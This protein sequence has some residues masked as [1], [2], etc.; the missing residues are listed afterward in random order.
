MPEPGA[1]RGHLAGLGLFFFALAV[2][3]VIWVACGFERVVVA[4]DSMAPALLPGDRL[5]VRKWHRKASGEAPPSPQAVRPGRP[6]APRWRRLAPAHVVRVGDVVVVPDPRQQSR[7]LVKRVAKLGGGS[8]WLAGDNPARSTDSRDFGPVELGSIRGKAVYRYAPASRAGRLRLHDG[9]LGAGA[10]GGFGP[11]L[12][13]SL[14]ACGQ[15][16]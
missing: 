5:L 7:A 16:F 3:V 14:S 11:R 4:G 1:R 9:G 8:A 2:A 13:A 12:A 15:R 6:P 10:P